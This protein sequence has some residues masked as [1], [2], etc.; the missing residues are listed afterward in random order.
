MLPSQKS[1]VD[2]SLYP[3]GDIYHIFKRVETTTTTTTTTTISTIPSSS[4]DTSSTTTT[5]TVTPAPPSS[6]TTITFNDPNPIS[7]VTETVKEVELKVDKYSNI[8]QNNNIS[9]PGEIPL[10]QTTPATPTN[11]RSTSPTNSPTKPSAPPPTSPFSKI[12]L[13][14]LTPTKTP[15]TTPKTT[16][17]TT[18]S[19]S[20][21]VS[22]RADD[23]ATIKT[24]QQE[25]ELGYDLEK[26]NPALFHE[27]FISHSMFLDH[28]PHMYE[29]ALKVMVEEYNEETKNLRDTLD[30]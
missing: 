18:P 16:P 28:M 30:N 2:S 25:K 20:P 29:H 12:P 10:I 23:K 14:Q 6:D 17:K 22:P 3:P 5:T 15:T 19:T 4:S 7:T 11:Q 8:N 27:I 9:S 24:T 21:Q 1:N 26:S 13:L